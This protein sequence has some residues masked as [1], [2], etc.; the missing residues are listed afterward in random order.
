MKIGKKL[1]IGAV[2]YDIVMVKELRNS[3]DVRVYAEID[4]LKLLISIDDTA[5][6]DQ[7]CL[8]LCHEI[9][10]MILDKNGYSMRDDENKMIYSEQFVDQ[11]S[12]SMHQIIEQIVEWQKWCKN[13]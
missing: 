2:T 6:E 1:T 13:E 12:L 4:D 3:E 8:S 9:V 10:H 11:F 7:H 5:R